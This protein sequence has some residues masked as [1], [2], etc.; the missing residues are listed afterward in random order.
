MQVHLDAQGESLEA[1]EPRPDLLRLL[2]PRPPGRQRAP[3][4]PRSGGIADFCTDFPGF[5]KVSL[6]RGNKGVLY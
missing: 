6:C 4:R 3:Q 1:G 2:C 5:L